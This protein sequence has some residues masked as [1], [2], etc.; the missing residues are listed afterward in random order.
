MRTEGQRDAKVGHSKGRIDRPRVW[1]LKQ[2]RREVWKET[3]CRMLLPLWENVI[4]NYKYR[5]QSQ[6]K[7][8]QLV[9]LP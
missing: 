2:G 3:T 5:K 1:S 6:T 9:G 4:L 8:S 7:A